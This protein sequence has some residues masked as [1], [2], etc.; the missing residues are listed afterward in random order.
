MLGSEIQNM[1]RDFPNLNDQNGKKT[2]AVNLTYNCAA[3]AAGRNVNCW[4]DPSPGH[5][6]RF[7]PKGVPETV[8]IA[9]FVA[10]YES[11]GFIRCDNAIPEINWSKIVIYSSLGLFTHAAKVISESVWSSK[12]GQNI[13]VSHAPDALNGPVYGIPCAFMKKGS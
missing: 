8:D 11:I 10:S 3:W 7:W 13:D 6:N 5:P 4:W 2:S 9:S 1:A 12:L